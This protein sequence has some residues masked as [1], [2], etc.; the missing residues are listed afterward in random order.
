MLIQHF[1]KI[2]VTCFV[3][4]LSTISKASPISIYCEQVSENSWY[5]LA[6]ILDDTMQ[7]SLDLNDE[8]E[9]TVAHVGAFRVQVLSENVFE[10]IDGK[11]RFSLYQKN[12][13]MDGQLILVRDDAERV[14]VPMTCF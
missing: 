8:S 5:S 13:H 4:S 9:G 14:I 6:L 3:V 1:F 10:S 12:G 7:I 2:V 11:L